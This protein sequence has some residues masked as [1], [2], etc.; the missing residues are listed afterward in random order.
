MQFFRVDPLAS[1]WRR[2]RMEGAAVSKIYRFRGIRPHVPLEPHD[3]E[4][5]ERRLLRRAPSRGRTGYAPFV[6]RP[7]RL[8]EHRG[9]RR[10]ADVHL[11]GLQL[12]RR[13][14]RRARRHLVRRQRHATVRL[15]RPFLARGVPPHFTAYD[16]PFLQWLERPGKQVDFISDSRP[17]RRRRARGTLRRAYDLIVFPGHHEYVT[18]T[19]TTWSSAT[20]TSAATSCSCRR[21]TSSGRSRCGATT[22]TRRCRWRDLRPPRVGADRRPVPPQRPRRRKGAVAASSTPT[23]WPW[24]FDGHRPAAPARGSAAAA[25]R[26]TTTTRARRRA[27]R[28]VAEIPNLM[29]RGVTAQMTYYETPAGAKV[30]AAGAFTLGGA[31]SRGRV[32]AAREPLGPPGPADAPARGRGA[33]PDAC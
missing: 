8:G 1:G 32:P 19:S 11:A 31:P 21:T 18:P 5:A 3:R 25:S 16:L 7:R 13:R 28:C 24:L 2:R 22:I 20:A 27:R 17:R 23:R 33:R 4:L 15:D 9:A 26:S 30:F 14:R 10:D 6:V 12:P 29:G